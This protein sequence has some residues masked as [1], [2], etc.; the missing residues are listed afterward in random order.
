MGLPAL[1][2]VGQHVCPFCDAADHKGVGLDENFCNDM[3][4]TAMSW[5]S[6]TD[7]VNEPVGGSA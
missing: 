5:T 2:R 6:S 1:R 7:A 4:G 3:V